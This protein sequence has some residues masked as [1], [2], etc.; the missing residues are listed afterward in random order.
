VGRCDTSD[1]GRGLVVM[2]R[3]DVLKRSMTNAPRRNG[4]YWVLR[5]CP[6][7]GGVNHPLIGRVA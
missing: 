2:T 5:P 3:L 6:T 1:R 7:M 4:P